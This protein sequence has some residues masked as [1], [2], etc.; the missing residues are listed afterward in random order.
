MPS[1]DK[2]GNAANSPSAPASEFAAIVPSDS[3][4]LA[5]LTR[6]IYVGGT[7]D[8]SVVPQ[9]GGAAVIFKAVPVGAWLPIRARR[10][11]ATGTTATNIVALW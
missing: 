9:S 8:I 3:V 4:D 2:A 11:N 7:G 10:I 6:F 1:I 5:Y